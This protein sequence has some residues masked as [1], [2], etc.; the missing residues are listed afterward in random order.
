MPGKGG[1]AGTGASRSP[2][3]YYI[4]GQGKVVGDNEGLIVAMRKR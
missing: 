4:Y 3:I 1:K 2:V